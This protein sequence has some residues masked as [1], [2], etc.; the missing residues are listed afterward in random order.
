MGILDEFF[1]YEG[2]SHF[3][4]HV[5]GQ[6]KVLDMG[7]GDQIL[8]S[9][10]AIF[11][12]GVVGEIKLGKAEWEMV[13]WCVS[14]VLISFI[15]VFTPNRIE[16]RFRMCGNF[17]EFTLFRLSLNILAFYRSGFSPVSW[18]REK[19]ISEWSIVYRHGTIVRKWR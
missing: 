11:G 7:T 18:Q 2:K 19:K 1:Q 3:A 4:N 14:R 10:H 17:F 15:I 13:Y 5:A 8:D 6:V 16:F 12:N 9:M